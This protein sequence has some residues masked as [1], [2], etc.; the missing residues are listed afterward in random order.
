MGEHATRNK[1]WD[2]EQPG[3]TESVLGTVDQLLVD[4]CMMDKVREHKRDLT[5]AY[6][7]Y[8]KT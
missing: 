7:D 6:Y 3:A 1:I 4:K 5:M 2:E 8:Q